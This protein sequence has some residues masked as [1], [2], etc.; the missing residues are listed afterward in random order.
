MDALII[1]KFNNRFITLR[2]Q[3]ITDNE[4]RTKW[5]KKGNRLKSFNNNTEYFRNIIAN[6][7]TYA[8]TFTAIKCRYCKE[9]IPPDT[10]YIKVKSKKYHID[11][12]VKSNVDIF[13]SQILEIKLK[14]F[15][16]RIFELCNS[17][18]RDTSKGNL[19]NIETIVEKISEDIKGKVDTIRVMI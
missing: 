13:C 9:D 4:A 12:F 17:L 7:Y 18:L 16:H 14:P 15:T 19:Q 1:K 10:R 2:T 8:W 5:F 6:M 11:C 3:Y